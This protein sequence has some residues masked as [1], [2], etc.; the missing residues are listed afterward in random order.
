M[1]NKTLEEL[2]AQEN[3]Y[4]P[5]VD[6]SYHLQKVTLAAVIGPVA[7]GKTTCLNYI[8]TNSSEIGRVQSFTTRPARPDDPLGDYRYLKHSAENI[9]VIAS[10]ANAGELVQYA[11]HPTTG[12]VYGSEASDY[13]RPYMMLTALANSISGLRRL[14]FKGIVE[15]CLVSEPNEWLRRISSRS[16][17]EDRL[18]R[19]K[20][21]IASL[22][23]CL[24]Q[25][26][27]MS[28][29]CSSAGIDKLPAV[30]NDMQLIIKGELEPNSNNREI[31]IKLLSKIRKQTAV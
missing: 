16:S 14:P 21:G 19:L 13:Y 7:V 15:L 30:C 8:S 31:G 10:K 20:E 28:W 3:S 12:Y 24:D 5:G 23:W 6:V 27:A 17:N 25:G 18:K 26:S 1:I 2:R 11:V 4:L 29:L 22:E 9:A